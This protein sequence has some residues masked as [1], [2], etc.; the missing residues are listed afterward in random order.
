MTVTKKKENDEGI[1]DVDEEQTEGPTYGDY[2]DEPEESGYEDQQEQTEE[3]EQPEEFEDEES[4]DG[5]YRTQEEV[6]RAIK[7]RLK[8]YEK[9]VS[10]DL[11]VSLEEAK[12]WIEAG[13]SVSQASGLTPAQIKMKLE[14]QK[15]QQAQ[16]AGQVYQPQ[17][18][19]VKKELAEMRSLI[20]EDREQKVRGQQEQEA[21][22]EFGDL[23]GKY[24]D[25]IMDK[26]EDL[27]LSLVDAA[28]I[29]LRPKLHEVAEDRVRNKQKVKKTRKVEDS[30]DSP[31]KGE[32]DLRTALSP[33]EKRVAQRMGLT[34][35]QYYEQKKE[36][37][38]IE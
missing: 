11:G 1:Y 23:Y 20:E 15:M 26:A 28:A 21:R 16:E 29:V 2:I 6:D 14:E 34:L 37:G 13:Q 24:Q 33:G 12:D 7:N 32:V 10:K 3:P 36:L 4:E 38:E 17:Q 31:D 22:K 18:D 35:E 19:D 30:S 27:G 5:V 25:D 8:R 9:K